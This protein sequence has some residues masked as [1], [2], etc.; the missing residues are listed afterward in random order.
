MPQPAEAV[1]RG[2]RPGRHHVHRLKCAHDLLGAAAHDGHMVEAEE[3]HDLREEGGP[4]Q[5]R[6]E[7]RDLEVLTDECQ[8]DTGES[9]TGADIAHGH[10]LGHDLGEHRAVQQVPLPQSGHLTRADQPALHSRLGQQFRVPDRVRE[11]IA[12]YLAR[13]LGRGGS[14]AASVTGDRPSVPLERS[15][16]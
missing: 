7:Q 15:G 1:E 16:R 6:F 10:A 9:G 8:R 14:S 13:L 3:F 2:D 5:Q 4:A 11:A 12:E